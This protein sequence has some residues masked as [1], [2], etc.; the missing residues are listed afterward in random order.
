MLEWIERTGLNGYSVVAHRPFGPPGAL[1]SGTVLGFVLL[2]VALAAIAAA[3]LC[4]VTVF[5]S[6]TARSEPHLGSG[7]EVGESSLL[8]I[9]RILEER[10]ARGELGIDEYTDRL[11]ALRQSRAAR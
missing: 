1:G 6:R 5:R 11:A 7:R 10:L 4:A 9:E 3:V 2:V 8:P